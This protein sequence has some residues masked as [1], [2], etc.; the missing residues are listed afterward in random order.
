MAADSV[1]IVGPTRSGKTAYLVNQ[2]KAW[3]QA[4]LG[5][6]RD[7][8]PVPMKEGRPVSERLQQLMVERSQRS[9]MQ[10]TASAILVFAA[11]GDNRLELVDRLTSATQGECPIQSA[12]PIGF[13]QDEV[14]LFWPLLVEQLQVKAQFP[15]RLRPENEQELATRLW[16]SQLTPEVLQRSGVGEYR[17][18]RRLLDWL[19]LAALAGTATE[20]IPGIVEVGLS[21]QDSALF[22]ELLCQWRS[23]CLERGLLTYGLL[24]ELYWR[25]LLPNLTY[26]QHL[27]RR[28]QAVLADDVDNYPAI[29]RQLFECLLEHG[30]VGAFTYNPKGGIRLGLGADPQHLGD[31]AT[32]CRVVELSANVNPGLANQVGLS[33]VEVVTDPLFLTQLPEAV[34]S[35]QT[36]SRAQLLRQTAQAIVQAVGSGQAQPHEI[37]VIGPGVDAIARYTLR[38]ILG[39]HGI[40]VE[41][42]ND[43]RPLASSAMVRALLTLLTLVY[44]NLGRLINR[45]AVAEMLVVLSQTPHPE[46]QDLASTNSKTSSHPTGTPKANILHP[47]IDP[48]R[49]GLLADH[50]FEPHPDSPRLLPTT[51][52]PRWDRL[53]YEATKAYDEIVRWIETQKLQQEQHLVPGA[54]AILDRAMQKFLWNGSHL[55]F[56][57]LATLRE[58]IETAQHYWEVDARL[59]QSENADT[60]ASVT[61]SNFIQLLRGG[62]ITADPYPVRT[63]RTAN[64]AVTLATIFQ[65]CSNRLSHRWQFWLDAG[66]PRWLTGSETLFGAPLFLRSWSGTPWTEADSMAALERRLQRILLDLLGRAGDRVFLC[67]SDLATN[68]QEQIGTLLSLVNASVPMVTE[69]MVTEDALMASST[70]P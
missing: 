13:F 3:V 2:F 49:A 32:R 41:S 52:F 48:V 31:L 66:S 29:A 37:A 36:T 51:E 54:I 16:R 47:S 34:Q 25:Y 27:S 58:L 64:Q 59:R 26:Q 4:G 12:T 8:P 42:I 9:Q 20:D 53:G 35:L 70:S 38:E 17:L 39:K 69:P 67:H 45:D 62:T 22:G 61:V 11:T 6:N 1:W 63:G 10:Q 60:P 57:Q 65:Y 18:V 56:D 24:C 19:Q 28:Y 14:L 5:E 40:A 68:G 50:C 30:A 43:Q 23:W 46:G 15:V 55:P 21:G 33:V 7:R 44:P